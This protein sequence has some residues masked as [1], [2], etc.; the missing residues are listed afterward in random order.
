[1]IID[2]LIKY[3]N[4][5]IKEHKKNFSDVDEEN[6]TFEMFRKK[7]DAS[8]YTHNRLLAIEPFVN[9]MNISK[10]RYKNNSYYDVKNL[11]RLNDRV[12]E[13]IKNFPDYDYL[14]SVAYEMLK[15]TKEYQTLWSDT[16]IISTEEKKKQFDQL[17]IDLNDIYKLPIHD[18]TA[19]VKRGFTESY[20][21]MTLNILEHGLDRLIKYYVDK[22]QIYVFDKEDKVPMEWGNEQISNEM[23]PRR[24]YKVVPDITIK[25]VKARKSNYYIPV[26]FDYKSQIKAEKFS[27]IDENIPLVAL[28]H[29]F[30]LYIE[31]LIPNNIR[32]SIV[33][34][35]TRPILRFKELPIVDVPLNLN[36]SAEELTQFVIKLKGDF[37]DGTIKNSINILYDT[38]FEFKEL[39]DITPFKMTKDNIARA[40][41]I[42]DLYKYING[43]MLLH[44]EKLEQL[45]KLDIE[46]AENQKKIKIKEKEFEINT[47][48]AKLKQQDK[49][50]IN[51][52]KSTLKEE[53]RKIET[54]T[55]TEITRIKKEYKKY[56]KDYHTMT[57][58]I[59]IAKTH[60]ITLYLCKQYLKFMRKYIDGLKYKE[61]VIGVK[62]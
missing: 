3:K 57:V 33:F 2:E 32:G 44:K 16:S 6:I 27:I 28:E 7:Y 1:M 48:I 59:S 46:E 51:N 56:A 12:Y 34:N 53:K 49:W 30:L 62:I 40:F 17:G 29:D 60:D 25:E 11:P 50:L 21:R 45:K 43:A 55:E 20:L 18:G 41:F 8:Y 31:D 37:E 36:L 58:V 24:I 13:E 19:L 5:K 22:K 15:R 54:E 10:P 47:N 23:M 39:K 9:Q 4:E 52:Y 35:F 38:K 61:L 14:N 42:Y 26:K